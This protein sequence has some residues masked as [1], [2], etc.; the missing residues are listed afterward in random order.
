M[1]YQKVNI[2]THS[3]TT[4]VA[5]AHYYLHEL[6]TAMIVTAMYY[7]EMLQSAVFGTSGLVYSRQYYG[8]NLFNF[9]ARYLTVELLKV[10]G[11]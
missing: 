5:T 6:M 4:S 11:I 3:F 10:S 1:R 2:A 8:G 9:L 7:I